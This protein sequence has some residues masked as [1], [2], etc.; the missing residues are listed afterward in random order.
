MIHLL[1]MIYQN[2]M[3]TNLIHSQN[4]NQQITGSQISTQ[5]AGIT[6]HGSIAVLNLTT[7]YVLSY[8][9]VMRHKL[10]HILVEQHVH[11]FISHCQYSMKNSEENPHHGEL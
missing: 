11:H 9:A 2:W 1:S 4:T 10:D 3:S 8:L 6:M 5:P 7:G